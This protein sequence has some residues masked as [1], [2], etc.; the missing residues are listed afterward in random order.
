MRFHIR[1]AASVRGHL[2][3]GVDAGKKSHKCV[4]SVST[5]S[6]A[7]ALRRCGTAREA[8]HRPAPLQEGVAQNGASARCLKRGGIRA[9][10][11]SPTRNCL[12]IGSSN[13]LTYLPPIQYFD[14]T[15]CVIFLISSS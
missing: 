7:E 12:E 11:G 5:I 13:A 1:I 4:F 10:R 15:I 2:A 8:A 3:A 6:L 14:N 9:A